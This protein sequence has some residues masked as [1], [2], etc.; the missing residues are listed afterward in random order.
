MKTLFVNIVN[1]L[2]IFL[3]KLSFI[4][5]LYDEFYNVIVSLQ[6]FSDSH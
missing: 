4:M 5:L 3:Y 2:V 6:L 1:V